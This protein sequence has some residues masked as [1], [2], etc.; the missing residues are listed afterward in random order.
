MGR[1]TDIRMVRQRQ[2]VMPNYERNIVTAETEAEIAAISMLLN[3]IQ[4]GS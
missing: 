1:R 2:K 4:T 3:K